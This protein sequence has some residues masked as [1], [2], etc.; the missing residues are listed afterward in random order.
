MSTGQ[1]ESDKSRNYLEATK[2]ALFTLSLGRCYEP[3]CQNRVVQMHGEHPIVQ[4]QISHIR[5]AK[6][7][8]PRYDEFMTD[9]ERRDFSNLLLLCTF[10][11]QLVDKRPTGDSYSVEELRAW[12]KER[13]G[14]LTD[15]LQA[16]T[17]EGLAEALGSSIKEIIDD[18]KTE[19]VV[20]I[21]HLDEKAEEAAS[22]L[23]TLVDHTFSQPSLD[24]DAVA[25][26]ADSARALENLPDFAPML[27]ESSHSL[28]QLPDYAL[29]L[30][31]SSRDLSNLPDYVHLLRESTQAINSLPDYA[32]MVSEASRG[33]MGLADYA[34]MLN[35]AAR[36]LSSTAESLDNVVQEARSLN[37]NGYI[38]KLDEAAQKFSDMSKGLA[39]NISKM[40]KAASGALEATTA[41]PLDRWT[42]IRNGLVAGIA[43]GLL[44]MGIIWYLTVSP[45]K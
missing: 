32:P 27:R 8:G 3:D 20:A 14:K 31:S 25:S 42:Y 6:E 45:V 37:S 29:M 39:G 15:D 10:H 24:M 4:V 30:S 18:T 2:K 7:N 26:L 9:D 43:L 22:L 19:L 23:R 5:A 40:E 34:P 21:G 1:H 35:E 38:S 13:E 36:S 33:L 44:L 11:H 17:E 41:P 28:E 16:L 12:K